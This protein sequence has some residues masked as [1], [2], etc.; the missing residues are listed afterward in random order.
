[1]LFYKLPEALIM[2]LFDPTKYNLLN[3]NY[4]LTNAS[5][6]RQTKRAMNHLFN[7]RSR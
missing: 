2:Y 7:C 4:V 5:L 1:M 3:L 6:L